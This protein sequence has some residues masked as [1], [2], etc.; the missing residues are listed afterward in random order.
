MLFGKIVGTTVWCELLA[1]QRVLKV[2]RRVKKIRECPH[3]PLEE[4]QDLQCAL[5]QQIEL[6]MLIL[7]RPRARHPLEQGRMLMLLGQILTS[8]GEIGATP[9][10]V[11][12]QDVSRAAMERADSILMRV[13]LLSST[14]HRT[15][16]RTARKGRRGRK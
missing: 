16:S 5:L 7:Q 6:Y 3:C 11:V 9:L 10:F 14:T 8:L 15:A 12:A 2:L 13:H 1:Q 4:R